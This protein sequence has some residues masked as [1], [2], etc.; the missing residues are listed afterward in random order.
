VTSVSDMFA[1]IKCYCYTVFQV[2]R[3]KKKVGHLVLRRAKVLESVCCCSFWY[4]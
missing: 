2:Q 4:I 3:Q 1:I